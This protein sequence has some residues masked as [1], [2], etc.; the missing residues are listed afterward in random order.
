MITPRVTRVIRVPS[1]RALQQTV[2]VLGVGF[3]PWACRHTA[4]LVPTA[5]AA[6]ELRRTLERLLL[7]ERWR[8]SEELRAT[9]GATTWPDRAGE[10]AFVA[11][12]LT[13]REGLWSELHRRDP[14]LPPRLNDYEREALL[15]S[16]VS[17]VQTAGIR[18]PFTIRPGL[19]AEMLALYDG[20]RRRYRTIDQFE[21]HAGTALLSSAEFDRGA[22]RLVQQTTFLAA[23]FRAYESRVTAADALDEHALRERLLAA[24]FTSPIRRLVVTVADQAADAFGLWQSDYDLLTRVPGLTELDLV[25]TDALL[26]SGFL[27]RLL[28]TLPEI[29]VVRLPA[30]SEAN[31]RLVV[32]RSTEGLR[33]VVLRDREEELAHIVRWLVTRDGPDVEPPALDRSAVVFQ[34]PL[35]YLY[36]GRTVFDAARLPFQ[37]FD[38]LPLAVEPFAVAFDVL[39]SVPLLDWTRAAL[40]ALLRS[41]QFAFVD[42]APLAAVDVTAFDDA[43]RE[44]EYLGG[45]EQ[46]PAFLERIERSDAVAAPGGDRLARTC[47]L[48]RGIAT[49]L[50]PLSTEAAAAGHLGVL[51]SFVDRFARPL[52]DDD[53]LA[54]RERRARQ[55]VR[56]LL[57]SLAAAHVRFGDRP[58]S[59]RD[60][61]MTLRRWIESQTFGPRTGGEGVHLVDAQAARFGLFRDVALVGL[62][63]GEWQ[64]G[65]SR[66][67]FYPASI[68]ANLG[69]P[70]EADRQ[71]AAR[72]AFADLLRL[73]E[74]HVMVTTFTLEDDTVVKPSTFLEDVQDSDLL[75]EPVSMAEVRTFLDEA[76]SIAPVVPE[77]LTGSARAWLDVRMA[78]S[79]EAASQ[80]PGVLAPPAD[81]ARAPRADAS[82]A[83]T[84]LETYLRCPFRYFAAYVL[85]LE[86]EQHEEIGLSP[87]ERGLVIHEIFEQFFRRW[88]EGGN[89][90]I[91]PANVDQAR[92]LMVA[93]ANEVLARVPAADRDIERARLLGSA[94][95]M[96]FAEQVFRAEMERGGTVVERLL[97][98]R[99]HGDYVIEGTEGPRTVRLR[100]V[101][102]RIDLL[103]DGELRLYDYK[104]SRAPVSKTRL[105]LP[106]YAWCAEQRLAGHRGRTWTAS[107]AA[108]L[109]TKES[110]GIARAFQGGDKRDAAVA[111]GLARLRTSV[112]G[113]ERGSFVVAPV[114]PQVC[115]FCPYPTVCRKDDL[116]DD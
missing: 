28:E 86:E 31:P 7:L 54:E 30:V 60:L 49:H 61:V 27:P 11:P 94:A 59:F 85:R 8:P 104:T 4:V 23:V 105:Q 6:D 17:D 16:A 71:S 19:M 57:E 96:G 80:P 83:V 53:P 50:A 64:S 74:E 52:G 2:A 75:G 5:S 44:V 89:G 106:V 51:A 37:A 102:D 114:E 77:A 48:V 55:A 70:K 110:D 46:L 108:Y 24:T 26:D 12:I 32:P 38:A 97:E 112:E 25:A 68:L 15:A 42:D 99:L 116:G 18:P 65:S 43:L 95:S 39:V 58:M 73:A 20:L 36:V 92:A 84:Y 66:N 100:G 3:G 107:E 56:G 41:P 79:L 78:A 45:L 67:I 13:T 69:W 88:T 87:R 62:V 91:A 109:A 35:P 63:E 93:V 76:L 115:T 34:R 29:E 98:H 9:L 81:A 40:V 103:A 113:I 21:Q 72:A 10:S 101:A 1:L 111:E 22:R 82:Y 47:R 33:H 90:A 14:N